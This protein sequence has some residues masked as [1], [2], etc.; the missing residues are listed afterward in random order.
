MNIIR[1]PAGGQT[2]DEVVIAKWHKS[3]GDFVRRGDVLLEIETDKAILDVESYCEGYILAILHM[4]GDSVS[5]G[6]EV[7]YIGAA[8]EE[9]P[10]RITVQTTTGDVDN[11]NINSHERPLFNITA[12]DGA[13]APSQQDGRVLSSPRAKKAALNA[14]IDLSEISV[15]TGSVIKENDVIGYLSKKTKPEVSDNFDLIPASAMR[16]TIARRLCSSVS[17]A[18]HYTVSIDIDMAACIAFRKMFNARLSGGAKVSFNDIIAKCAAKAIEKYPIINASYTDDKIKVYHDVNVGFAV[19]VEDGLVVPVVKQVNIKSLSVIAHENSGNIKCARDNTLTAE[20]QTGG[21]ITI[22]NLGMYGVGWFTAIINPP[23]GCVL[24]IGE[25]AEKAVSIEGEIVSRMMMSITA[26]F[27][28][29]LID[30]ALGARFLAELKTLLE[31]PA[32]LSD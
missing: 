9:I 31:T 18:P 17:T 23:E 29:R 32:V 4:E 27:D 30:G 11:D 1:I 2:T 21:T 8:G 14:G 12:V 7:A 13:P 26:S 19:E 5:A 20:K 16:R 10:E 15:N 25:I 24:A 6:A 3:E 22:S 28:H